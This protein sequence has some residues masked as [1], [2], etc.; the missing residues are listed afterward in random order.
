[1]ALR[2]HRVAVALAVTVGSVAGPVGAAAQS[3]L[4]RP[5]ADL[6]V[7]FQERLGG[8]LFVFENT[9]TC[10]AL[11]TAVTIDLRGTGGALVFDTE[12]GGG[13]VGTAYPF[14]TVE[15]A[16]RLA[17]TA[18]GVDG[19]HTLTLGF[20]GLRRGERVVISI[21]VD[22]Q[23]TAGSP[24]LTQIYGAQFENGTVT[25]TLVLPGGAEEVHAGRFD[26]NGWAF[27]NPRN[28]ALS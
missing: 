19:G 24:G 18:G 20:T 21:D 22:E 4:D 17:A 27:V 3:A 26:G 8:D 23:G 13:G 11:I 10:E 5:V 2:W 1:M 15:G 16:D 7:R 9:G 28:C 25:A 12:A 6:T 14:Y